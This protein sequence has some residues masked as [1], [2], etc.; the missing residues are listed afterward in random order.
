MAHP[1]RRLP[2]NAPGDFY[3]DRSCID[4]GT[5]R[6]MAGATFADG[7]DHAFVATQ[8]VGEAERAAALQAL[9]ACPTA[10]IGTLSKQD[11][12]PARAAFP[13]PIDGNVFHCGYH[14]E[15]SFGA[16]SYFVERPSGNVLVDSPRFTKP[17]VER[18]EALGG[19]RTLL[20][21]HKDD[22]ADHAKYAAHFHA[23]RVLHER[24]L[25]ARTRDVERVLTGDDPLLLDADFLAIPTPG[26]TEG[27][28]SY[29]HRSRHLFSGDH[30]A[31]TRSGRLVAFDDACWYDWRVQTESMS[32]L[33]AH[34]FEWL[35]PGHGRRA[36]LAPGTSRAALEELVTWMRTVTPR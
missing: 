6:W 18:L 21:T 4:C 24:D 33:A 13:L 7:D 27:S 26:H 11:L 8:P 19:V 25:T 2:D 10:S 31:A 35:L 36:H 17:L 32:R 20:L 5:C 23:E 14:A 29:L 30:L 22:V 3:V 1:D 16:T 28:V 34:D 12:A 9:L 15:A